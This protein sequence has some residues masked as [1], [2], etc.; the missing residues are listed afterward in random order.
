MSPELVGRILAQRAR[1]ILAIDMAEKQNHPLT[2][3]LCSALVQSINAMEAAFNEGQSEDLKRFAD[4]GLENILS[5][6]EG[7]P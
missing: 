1:L 6:L 7:K 2:K 3:S 5:T 4:A